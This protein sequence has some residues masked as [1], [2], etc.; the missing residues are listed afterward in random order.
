MGGGEAD[1]GAFCLIFAWSRDVL[2][3]GICFEKF[4]FYREFPSYTK[5][6]PSVL[7][8]FFIVYKSTRNAKENVGNI[9]LTGEIAPV[10][11]KTMPAAL[12]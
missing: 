3:F 9:K 8:K 10:S 11:Q 1:S 6:N 2:L 4:R 7:E 12:A 5:G